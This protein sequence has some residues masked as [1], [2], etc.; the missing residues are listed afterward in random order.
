MSSGRSASAPVGG[1]SHSP[2]SRR[3]ALSRCDCWT[4]Y[5]LVSDEALVLPR[6]LGRALPSQASRASTSALVNFGD[7]VG[8]LELG[9]ARSP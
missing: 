2:A 3:G 1:S 4:D 8:D 6:G 5:V 9:G 7:Y